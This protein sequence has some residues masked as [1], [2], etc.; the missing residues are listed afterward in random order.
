[1]VGY[2]ANPAH[3]EAVKEVRNWLAD[4]EINEEFV[5]V[6][7]QCLKSPKFPLETKTGFCE[8]VV[9]KFENDIQYLNDQIQSYEFRDPEKFLETLP[10]SKQETIELPV[11]VCIDSVQLEVCIAELGQQ[12]ES[13]F[14][15][16][17]AAYM[18]MFFSLTDRSNCLLHNQ[19]RYV[20]VWLPAFT[21]LSRLKHSQTT[22]LSQLLD[23]L[24]WHYNVT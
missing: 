23:W 14:R 22:S 17:I 4:I 19:T 16:P 9:E 2:V 3:C 18:E 24:I 21:S 13:G 10:P 12:T 5:R 15:D 1:M 6:L 7:F 20:H 11:D 8:L